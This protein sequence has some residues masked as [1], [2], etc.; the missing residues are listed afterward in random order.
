VI[1]TF[2]AKIEELID[3]SKGKT[4]ADVVRRKIT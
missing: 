2:M 3:R 1:D 4:R